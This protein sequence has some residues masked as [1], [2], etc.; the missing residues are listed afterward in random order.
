MVL[1]PTSVNL[2]KRLLRAADL[3]NILWREI[4]DEI[5]IPVIAE[6]DPAPPELLDVIQ[7][8]A[9]S[10]LQRHV[11][12][13]SSICLVLHS[14]TVQDYLNPFTAIREIV[15]SFEEETETDYID[16]NLPDDSDD[17]LSYSGSSVLYY[18][19]LTESRIPLK[20]VLGGGVIIVALYIRSHEQT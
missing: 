4:Q 6:G 15:Q 8:R 5:S 10:V 16:T 11:N 19:V 14:A 7:C 1:P 17:G 3:Y 18:W 20:R 2:L 13:T 12:A 9:K